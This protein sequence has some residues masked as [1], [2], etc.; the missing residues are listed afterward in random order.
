MEGWVGC[1]GTVALLLVPVL[2]WNDICFAFLSCSCTETRRI[3]AFCNSGLSQNWMLLVFCKKAIK[4]NRHQGRTD[5]LLVNL[6]CLYNIIMWSLQKL[7]VKY[8]L[9]ILSYY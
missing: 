8:N 3:K 9:S 6:E 2:F 4:V 7:D 5:M 1:L